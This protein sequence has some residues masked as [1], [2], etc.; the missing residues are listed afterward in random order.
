MNCQ[1]CDRTNRDKA[2]YCKWCGESVITKSN[3]PLQELVGMEQEKNQLQELVIACENLA[4]RAKQTGVKI[5]LGMDTV[6]TGNTGTGKTKLVDVLQKLLYS[7]GI[8]KNATA[9]IVD[10]VD[11]ENFSKDETV[12]DENIKKCKGGL[13]VIENAQKLLPQKT[14]DEVNQLDKLFKCM[15]DDWDNDPIVVLTGLSGLK[16]FINTNP[17]IAARFEYHFDLKDYSVENLT[18]ICEHELQTAYKL[19]L[20]DDARAK[21]MRIFTND[22]RTKKADFGNGH[23]AIKRATDIFT[24]VIKRDHKET[25]VLPD[26]VKGTEFKQKTYDEIMAELDQF[27]GIDEIR[28]TVLKIINKMDFERERKGSDAKREIKDHF[29]FLGNPGTGKTTIARIFADILNSLNVLPI[30]QLVEVARKDL[31]AGYLGQTAIAVEDAVERAMGG[32]LFI[33][34][35]YALKQGDNDPFGQEA[36]DTLLKLVEDN[37]GKFVAIAAGYTKEMGDFL[38]SNSGMASRFNE[39]VNFKDY[40]AAELT[41][42]FLR[43]VKKEKLTLDNDASANIDNFFKK[44]YIS[45]DTK[46]FGNAREV[47][48][49]FDRALKNQG[50]RLQKLRGSADYTPDMISI[51]TRAD[52]EGEESLKEKSLD[53]ILAELNEFIGMDSVKKEVRELANKLEFDR[54]MMERGIGNA[55]LTNVHVVLSGNPGTGKTTIALKLGE[56][57]KA[58]GLLPTSKVVEKE[59]KDLMSGFMNETAKVVDKA[60]DEAMGGILFIDEAYMLLGMDKQGNKNK[61]GEEAVASLMTRMVKDAGKFVVIC[62]GYKKEMT[63][64]VDNANPGFRRRFTHFLNIE[65]YSRDELVDIFILNAKKSGLK[66]SSDAKERLKQ[67]VTIMVD[68]KSENFGNAGEMTKL[69]NQVKL[70]K[71]NRLAQLDSQGTEITPEIYETIEPDDIPYEKPKAINEDECFAELN[72]LI[73]LGSVKKTVKEIAD[74]IKVER[75]KAEA[76]GKKFQGVGD[77]YLFVGNPGTG[78]TTVARIMGNIFYSLGVLP[79]NSLVEVTRKD[80]VAGYIGQ[81]ALQTEKAVKSAIGGVFFID[82]AYSLKSGGPSDFGQ[83]ATDTI[84]PMMLDYKGKMVFIAAG[85]PRE[86]QGWINTN[87]GLE[88]RFT[89]TIHFEDY[90]GEEMAEIF[91]MKAKKDQLELTPEAENL[92][93]AYFD[94]LYNNRSNNFANAREVNNY[95]DKVKKNQSTRLRKRMEA[96]DFNAA[97]FKQLIDEDMA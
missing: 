27:V 80:L 36:I 17:N 59:A 8:V 53:G 43:L 5:R 87:S 58:I 95:F 40:N 18:D 57:F 76:L 25:T 23:L 6:I 42:I 35:A 88:S 94:D 7:T 83:E 19:T 54:K 60:C 67:L 26:D 90:T 79:S 97:E 77:H 1:K 30:G 91:M 11:Y 4:K 39:T 49:A 75:A 47:R 2:I 31:V 55:E 73:G 29:L 21:L 78:K 89:K 92:M 86:I 61:T 33:D 52:I 15:N 16:A 74:Y 63:E 81:T 28:E 62:A 50:L 51:L 70:R 34:E 22:F 37:R 45:R 32:I 64:F 96:D 56:I 48:N 68:A 46:S 66:L 20:D 3:A 41:E 44:M 85:Y 10:A 93:H 69:L 71:Q 65:D 9:M 82:E 12:W 14:S 38:S 72:E 24:N 13:L 84:L